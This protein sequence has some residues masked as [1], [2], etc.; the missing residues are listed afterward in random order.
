MGEK[1]KN[2]RRESG[3]AEGREVAVLCTV[4]G[5]RVC[6]CVG[7]SCMDT[8][9]RIEPYGEMLRLNDEGTE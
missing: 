3:G 8:P 1:S 6:V 2:E 9:G 7:I 4:E 5:R